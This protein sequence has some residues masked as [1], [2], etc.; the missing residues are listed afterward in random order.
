MSI[1]N[2]QAAPPGI[3]PGAA[4]VGGPG[5]GQTGAGRQP[6]VTLTGVS[7]RYGTGPRSV[8]ALDQVSLTVGRGEFVCLI[9]ASGCGKSTLLSVVA[10]LDP[11]TSPSAAG[12]R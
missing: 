9:G 12:W 4:A 1:S 3:A 2:R 8:L 10:G 7:K 11:A 5:T 6:A